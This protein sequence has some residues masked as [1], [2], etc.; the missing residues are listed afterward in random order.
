MRC[1]DWKHEATEG[2]VF[3]R[4]EKERGNK[5]GNRKRGKL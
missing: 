1:E 2:G 3:P 5:I 4:S